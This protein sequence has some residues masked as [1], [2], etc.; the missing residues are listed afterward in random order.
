MRCNT[1]EANWIW[2]SYPKSQ[3]VCQ[4]MLSF[5]TATLVVVRTQWPVVSLPPIG[6]GIVVENKQVDVRK[7]LIICE[8][9]IHILGCVLLWCYDD[10]DGGCFGQKEPSSVLFS[11]VPPSTG[12]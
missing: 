12:C 7:G 9:T 4:A 11:A 2:V 5:G 10:D 6:K 1:T 3:F 8:L